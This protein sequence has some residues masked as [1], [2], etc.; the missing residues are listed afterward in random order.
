MAAPTSATMSDPTAKA[1]AL[2]ALRVRVN[3]KGDKRKRGQRQKGRHHGIQHWIGN[4][5]A[6][7]AP[8]RGPD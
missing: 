6:G 5:V 1:T 7:E 2:A 3:T 4:A 8:D